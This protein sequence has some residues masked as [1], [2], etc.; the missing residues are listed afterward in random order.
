MEIIKLNLIPSGVN[1]IC[2]CSQY[3]NGRVI[4]LELFDGLTPYTLQSGDTVTLNVRKPDNTILTA[5]V[6]ATQGNNYVDIVTTEQMCAVV[7]NNLCDLT[8]TN[9]STVIGTLNF[10][11]Q[12]E[13]DVLADG[14]P[15][16]S[17]IEDLD[18]L[19]AEAVEAELGDNYY[20]KGEVDS[21]LALKADK[22]ALNKTFYVSQSGNNA[23]SGLDESHPLATVNKALELGAAR[24][25]LLAG[26]YRQQI[27]LSKSESGYIEIL[28]ASDTSTVE[29]KPSSIHLATS[30]TKV[31]NTTK[32]YQ[33]NISVTLESNNKWIWQR[34]VV[35][36]STIIDNSERMPQQ[37]GSTARLRYTRIKKCTSN[38]LQDAINEIDN[39]DE[40]LWYVNNGVLYFSRPSTV[41]S[42]H[43]LAYSNGQKL[44]LNGTSKN[45]I[46]MTGIDTEFMVINIDN[47]V[48]SVITDC[49]SS[50]A[51]GAGA[52]TYDYALNAKFIRCEAA[53]AQS[54]SVGDGFNAHGKTGGYQRDHKT[55]GRLFDCWSHDNNDDG[56]SD[57]EC[58]ESEVYGGLFE[59]NGKAG[60]TPSYGSHC[61]CVGVYSRKNYNG[62]FYT[63]AATQA[64]LGIYGQL[65]CI[66]C[67]AEAN[68]R[69]TS[70]NNSGYQIDSNG[71]RMILVNCKSI[72]NH[73]GY[74]GAS[75]TLMTIIDC[76]SSGDT[77]IKTGSGTKTIINSTPVTA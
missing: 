20:T 68:I 55:T 40:Y 46:I 4:R 50:Y 8:I 16:Q 58:C 70:Q 77:T 74:Y 32:V 1:S 51:Y 34:N 47:T 49:C 64:E 72:G 45:T 15:S 52:F 53:A 41:D 63:G 75:G 43:P 48:N 13:R 24:V 27:D 10:Y 67:V 28:K 54:G 38:N 9:G 62:F 69:G 44:F 11:M 33:T 26:D 39:A 42:G 36:N 14:I 35:D 61:K 7:G 3:D 29:F 12:V 56:F 66:D 5:S 6:T 30:E 22:T 59:Y 31:D 60:I 19:V 73:Y 17:V 71:N 65:E 18:A 2:H 57:H 37:R 23:N 21:A 76:G 25:L